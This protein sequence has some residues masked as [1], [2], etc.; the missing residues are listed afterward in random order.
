MLDNILRCFVPWRLAGWVLSV[1]L[2]Y[3]HPAIAQVSISPLVIEVEAKRGQAQGII[4][5]GNTTNEPFRARV[6]AEP[7]IYSR[8]DGF[9]SLKK[10]EGNDLTPY[11]QFS[12]TEL[13]IPAG[14]NRR[15]RFIVRLAPSLPEGEYRAVVFTENLKQGTNDSGNH[16][17]LVTRIGVTIYVRKGDLSP[18]LAVEGASWNS[19]HKQIQLLVNNTGDASVR[20]KVNWTL[21]QQETVVTTGNL[22]PTGIIARSQR[23]FLLRYPNDHKSI[24]TPGE[25]QLSGEL[26]WEHGEEQSTKTFS[27]PLT[28]PVTAAADQ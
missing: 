9:Q 2:F 13:N 26:I 27:V 6:Y 23:N 3:P 17:G 21:K 10:G 25:Y 12:P 5:V 15:I 22:N 11:L 20:P 7:F 24:L 8:D 19:K 1:G 18:N 14:I 4:N 28:I 16:I